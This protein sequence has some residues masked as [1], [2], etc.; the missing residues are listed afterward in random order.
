MEL[1][2]PIISIIGI[3][4]MLVFWA[5]MFWDMTNNGNLP[6][7]VKS[8]WTLWFVFLSIFAAMY[9]YVYEYRNRN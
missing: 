5:W 7:S 6:S 8:T 9:Y 1:L 3:L 4:L 2:V